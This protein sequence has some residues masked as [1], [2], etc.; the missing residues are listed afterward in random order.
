MPNWWEVA[1][2]NILPFYKPIIENTVLLRGDKVCTFLFRTHFMVHSPDNTSTNCILVLYNSANK[3]S[4]LEDLVCQIQ[5]MLVQQKLQRTVLSV[6]PHGFVNST[7]GP[8]KCKRQVSQGMTQIILRT[9]FRF[10]MGV[11][12][13]LGQATCFYVKRRLRWYTF[14]YGDIQISTKTGDP[15]QHSHQAPVDPRNLKF[16]SITSYDIVHQAIF[17]THA[18]SARL[19]R[20]HYDSMTYKVYI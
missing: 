9:L 20:E 18:T 3:H 8:L 2:S 12:W 11:G 10:R 17:S 1:S 14:L 6:P 19:R 7:I 16:I 4:I 13:K 5:T 15:S